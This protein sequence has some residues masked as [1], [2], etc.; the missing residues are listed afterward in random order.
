MQR[1]TRVV[2]VFFT[3]LL[4]IA[5]CMPAEK[6]E[7]R[8]P[9]PG[10]YQVFGRVLNQKGQ[11]VAGCSVFLVKR[12]VTKKKKSA[13]GNQPEQNMEE[14]ELPLAQEMQGDGPGE[15][16]TVTTDVDGNYFFV[17]EPLGANNFWLFFMAEGYETRSMAI[18]KLMSSRFFQKPNKSPINISVVL[19][20]N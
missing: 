12:T 17:F 4:F 16:A 3:V 18:N 10:M 11:P 14:A 1:M 5:F 20:K 8:S 15:S 6:T 2:A 7:A 19:E 13:T 9:A